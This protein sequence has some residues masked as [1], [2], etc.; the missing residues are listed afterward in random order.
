MLLDQPFEFTLTSPV[1]TRLYSTYRFASQAYQL[2]RSLNQLEARVREVATLDAQRSL[3]DVVASQSSSDV[4][5]D[6]IRDRRAH[7]FRHDTECSANG[8]FGQ[9]GFHSTNC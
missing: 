6:R 4:P 2:S 8:C 3:V 7:L 1:A 9:Q 5:L